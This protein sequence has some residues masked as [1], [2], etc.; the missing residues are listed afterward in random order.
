MTARQMGQGPGRP[1]VAVP[2]KS[3]WSPE[4]GPEGLGFLSSTQVKCSEGKQR[5]R[6]KQGGSSV[7]LCQL[8]GSTN[9]YLGHAL[10]LEMPVCESWNK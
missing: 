2:A 4:Q 7:I 6:R 5:P 1:Q 3:P 8:S 10:F 9:T